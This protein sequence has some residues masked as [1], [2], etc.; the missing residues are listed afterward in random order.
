MFHK[1][2]TPGTLQRECFTILGLNAKPNSDNPIGYFG[3]GLKYAIAVIL[4]N[5]GTI[6]IETPDYTAHFVSKTGM[7]RGVPYQKI[8]CQINDDAPFDLP[9][10]LEYGKN[11]EPWMAY[12][13]L[14]TNTLDEGGS[15]AEPPEGPHTTITVELAA[16]NDVVANFTDY[17][18]T[19]KWVAS[20]AA[21]SREQTGSHVIETFI[22]PTARG[23]I[24]YKGIKV[25]QNDTNNT[26]RL[27]RYCIA[28]N[29]SID[30]TEDRTISY[31]SEFSPLGATRLAL[32]SNDEQFVRELITNHTWGRVCPFYAN[33]VQPSAAYAKVVKELYFEGVELD[34][35]IIQHAREHNILD[36][37]IK[38]YELKPEVLTQLR[39]AGQLVS[40]TGYNI[41]NYEIFG[42]GEKTKGN[43]RALAEDGVILI[44][45]NWVMQ[46]VPEEIAAI[47]LE[48]MVHIKTGYRDCTREL[49]TYLFREWTK[50]TQ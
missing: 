33:S 27:S 3:T 2:Y 18:V 29:K 11:W 46:Q 8:V 43:I 9:L 6:V 16:F 10:T 35:S 32:K 37:S 38:R 44:D 31:I 1:F 14:Y 26:D 25:H 24:F 47:L 42:I 50:A 15:I 49:Q 36:K 7:F 13:E 28:I 17:F 5:N 40:G 12:R 45:E 34:T 23:A 41:N 20:Q 22:H 30:L 4:R 39:E 19:D 48:E 21:H